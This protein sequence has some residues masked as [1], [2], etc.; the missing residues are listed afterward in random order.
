MKMSLTA[1]VT[2]VRV[3]NAAALEPVGYPASRDAILTRC[4]AK[5]DVSSIRNSTSSS[6]TASSCLTKITIH[7][8]DFDSNALARGVFIY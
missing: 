2:S 6:G 5:D 8:D 1:Q 3:F 7:L 4:F